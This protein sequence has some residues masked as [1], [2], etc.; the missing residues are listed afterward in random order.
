MIRLTHDNMA[1]A[2]QVTAIIFIFTYTTTPLQNKNKQATIEA[3]KVA[4]PYK[5]ENSLMPQ[6][7]TISHSFNTPKNNT[8]NHNFSWRTAQSEVIPGTRAAIKRESIIPVVASF[9][10]FNQPVNN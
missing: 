2:F 3:S 9:S 10:N 7:K 8:V 4:E 1:T 5:A 6:I